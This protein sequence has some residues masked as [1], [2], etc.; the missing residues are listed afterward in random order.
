MIGKEGGDGVLV[1]KTNIL[2]NT[3]VLYAIIVLL[4][5]GIVLFFFLSQSQDS[6]L[7]YKQTMG[8]LSFLV[9]VYGLLIAYQHFFQEPDLVAMVKYCQKVY[10]RECGTALN[11]HLSAVTSG[12]LFANTFYVFF[13]DPPSVGFVVQKTAVGYKIIGTSHLD[14]Y[15]YV[16][17]LN[18]NRVQQAIALGKIP[19]INPYARRMQQ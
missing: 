10:F 2:T 13:S 12:P 3:R 17:L 6:F 11:A 4:V 5:I 8:L 9:V 14:F 16:R 18:D 1:E 19:L 15:T 7:A